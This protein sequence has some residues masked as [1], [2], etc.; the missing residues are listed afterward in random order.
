MS[1]VIREPSDVAPA[2]YVAHHFDDAEQQFEASTLGMW[3]FL[4]TEVLFFG[5]ALSAFAY[6][7][8][9]NADAFEAASNH[10]D[11]VAGTI[12]T[13]V[14]LSSSL[15]MVLAVHAA[16]TA[17]R[18]RQIFWL[19]VTFA[20]GA[21]FLGIKTY[22]Y[23]HKFHEGLVPGPFFRYAG[24]NAPQHEM[25]ISF[26]FALTG[27][28]ALHMIIGLGIMGTLTVLSWRGWFSPAYFTPVEVSGLYWHF[29]D[30]VW[31]FLFPLLY[32]LGRH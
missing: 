25:F 9:Q 28:H 21:A 10:L 8:W 23:A 3:I 15:S 11:L 17:G 5:G 13:A 6:Y 22:E 12:N 30:I 2:P 18:G 29:V 32:L 31:I 20:L 4:A 7:Y 24:P 19:L 27:L 26:Y 14:L 16:Q 1:A